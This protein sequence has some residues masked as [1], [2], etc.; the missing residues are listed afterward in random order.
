MKI[1]KTILTAAILM[2]AVS[3]PAQNKSDDIHKH[4]P[5]VYHE[6]SERCGYQRVGKRGSW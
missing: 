2:A 6:P 3:L 4:R 5:P 1:K